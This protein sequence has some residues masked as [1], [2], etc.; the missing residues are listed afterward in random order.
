MT[1]DIT[2][3]IERAKELDRTLSKDWKFAPCPKHADRNDLSC[4]RLRDRDGQPVSE[5]AL[6]FAAESRTLLPQLVA[7]VERLTEKCAYLEADAEGT[8]I[9]IGVMADTLDV[10]RIGK[11]LSCVG[12]A[13]ERLV[14]E[15]DN[16]KE[17]CARDDAGVTIHECPP[18]GSG[19]MPC[20]GRPPFEVSGDRMTKNPALVNCDR[21][22]FKDEALRIQ[23]TLTAAQ[24]ALRDAIDDAV[25]NGE[26]ADKLES[27]RIMPEWRPLSVLTYEVA[28]RC[29][30]W[31]FSVAGDKV[32]TIR[33]I[34]HLVEYCPAKNRD[35][36]LQLAL[37]LSISN[38]IPTPPANCRPVDR[39]GVPVPWSEVGL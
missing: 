11:D 5:I 39:E 12:H 9:Y 20:C 7:E 3:A 23:V 31:V 10:K 6:R 30:M 13:I 17:R 15:R 19:V 36:Q 8:D 4:F 14:K 34:T 16:L 29:K 33:D 26:R 24:E 1:D 18:K 35:Y 37:G 21:V 2:K 28:K 32:P 27:S 38:T 25:A 22:R